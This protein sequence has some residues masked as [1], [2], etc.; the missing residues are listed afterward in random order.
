MSKLRV[1]LVGGGYIAQAEHIPGWLQTAD[2]ELVGVV[3][4][5]TE[6]ADELGR[7]LSLPAFGSFADA[8]DSLQADAAHICTPPATH[9]ELIALATANGLH[10]LVEKP[11]ALDSQTAERCGELARRRGLLL[12]VGAPRRYDADFEYLRGQVTSGLLGKVFAVASTWHMA[13]PPVYDVL[14]S[15]PRI[16]NDEYAANGFDTIQARLLDESIHHLGLLRAMMPG[17]ISVESVTG[18]P[19]LFHVVL[20]IGDAV[21]WHSNARGINHE[22]RITVYAERG[23]VT[24]RPWSPHFPWSYGDTTIVRES[25]TEERPAIARRNPY[26]RQLADFAEA[27]RQPRTDAFEDAIDDVRLV[28]DIIAAWLAGGGEASEL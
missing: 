19:D 25:G 9:E 26:W 14:V 24:A 7:R 8:I 17:K 15:A 21:A 6:V 4:L 10:V 12:M 23:C 27:C 1:I 20:R 5:R 2:A 13:L 11:L 22:E 18:S 3:D 16:S 28:E